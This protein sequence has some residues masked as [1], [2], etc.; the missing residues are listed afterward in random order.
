M[1]DFLTFR[2][3]EKIV[4]EINKGRQFDDSLNFKTL[5][6]EENRLPKIVSATTIP[7]ICEFDFQSW[8]NYIH[9]NLKNKTEYI[10][11]EKVEKFLKERK[12]NVVFK[13][14]NL[15]PT[16]LVKLKELSIKPLKR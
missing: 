9:N 6:G 8:R 16:D 15:S 11:Y 5:N 14:R 4:G 2:T 7:H 1:P 13:K 10:T 12:K 3:N